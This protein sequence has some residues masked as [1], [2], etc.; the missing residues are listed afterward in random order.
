MA[1][2]HKPQDRLVHQPEATILHIDMDAFFAA[3]S[4][5][6]HPHL[7]GKPVI[8]GRRFGRSVV[9]S[10][11]YE[12][13]KFGVRSAMPVKKALQLCPQAF[14]LEPQMQLYQKFSRNIMAIFRQVTPQVEQLSIDEAFLDVSG[15]RKLW[16]SPVEI[17]TA[18][19]RR[20]RDETGLSCS[21]GVA[22]NKF[23][24]KMASTR[25]KPN[26][27][28][29]IPPAETLEFLHPLP[30][31]ELWGVGKNTAEKLARLGIS[32]IADLATTPVATLLSA[33][34]ESAA[35]KL[36][37][38]SQGIDLRTIVTERREK[39]IGHEITFEH[40]QSDISL[41]RLE[42]LRHS[43]RIA[44]RLRQAGLVGRTVALKLK[45]AD[46]S[47]VARSKTLSEPTD[48]SHT[49][50]DHAVK[51][52]DALGHLEGHFKQ[53]VRLVGVRVEQLSEANTERVQPQLWQEPEVSTSQLWRDAESIVDVLDQRFGAGAVTRAS[54]LHPKTY[55]NASDVTY[56]KNP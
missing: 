39:S 15:V 1:L 27:M 56:L 17:A 34:G 55:A 24:A 21:V 23:V 48:L 20:V 4:L 8:I 25:A 36:H 49:I 52:C 53:P 7:Q 5:L 19:R 54:L 47:T 43:D 18:I 31:S 3:V 45:F 50:Y 46:F 6:E 42:L 51:L 26:G 38:L 2:P 32:T 28:L 30:V 44:S 35:R 29:V 41:I 33:L 13:R 22:E 14:V 37:E 11:S 16:G 9:T 12:A 40:D 10:A